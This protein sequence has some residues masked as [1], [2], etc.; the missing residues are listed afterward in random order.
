VRTTPF[1][2]AT[3]KLHLDATR[4]YSLD[5][6]RA[7][8]IVLVLIWHLQP[9]RFKS[10]DFLAFV[11]FVILDQFTLVAVPLFYLIS[12]S[13]FFAHPLENSQYLKRRLLRIGELYIFWTGVQVLAYYVVCSSAK[14][15]IFTRISCELPS[16]EELLVWGG[17]A[18]PFVA[19]SVF[20]FLSFLFVLTLLAFVYARL[21]G[22][23]RAT[24][25]FAIIFGCSAYFEFVGLLRIPENTLSWLIAFLPYVP[26]AYVL[27]SGISFRKTILVLLFFILFSAH[28]ILILHSVFSAYSRISILI[29]SVGIFCSIRSL[30]LSTNKY[31][32]F[33]SKHS[34]G[35]FSVHKYWQLLF[36]F[37]FS[38]F[39]LHFGFSDTTTVNILGAELYA[40]YIPIALL[41]VITS[42]I[43]VKMVERTP[44]RKYVA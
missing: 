22:R 41:A 27:R 23:V 44:L 37:V 18:L 12:M 19:G 31:V 8:A 14:Y 39:F 5:L 38:K 16:V 10:P 6:V 40:A 34:L 25:G 26:L 2:T 21:G 1:L 20:Y 4:N 11:N 15:L 28:D 33:L 13:L 43:S 36:L 9:L 32:M 35:L 7:L 3:S 24:V 17:P 29:G 42:L 30:N